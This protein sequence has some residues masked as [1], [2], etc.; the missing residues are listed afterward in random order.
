VLP[1]GRESRPLAVV[2]SGP[3]GVGKDAVLRSLRERSNPAHFTV[4]CTTRPM[5]RGEKQGREYV[6][7]SREEF[8]T[9]KAREELLEWAEVY[10][11]Y[12]GV[13]GKPVKQ[14]LEQG[15]DVFIKVDVQG[16]ASIKRL[17]PEAVFIFLAPPTMEELALRLKSRR[18]NAPS[19]L[20][21]R[22]KIAAEEMTRVTQFDYAVVNR[23]DRLEEAV[24]KVEAI[25][26]AEKC[27]VKQR[28][29]KL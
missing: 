5:R 26:T 24:S 25:V 11:H 27:R 6:F 12:Y 1:P 29:V 16:A 22:L 4:T 3:S 23:Q 15:R 17:L 8:E 7:V 28:I 10:G 18:N 14:A 2:L 13:P 20:A 19:D 21:L 9:M